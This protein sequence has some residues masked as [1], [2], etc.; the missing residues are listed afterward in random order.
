M[1]KAFATIPGLVIANRGYVL[2]PGSTTVL[3][4]AGN[5]F[6]MLM[7]GGVLANLIHNQAQSFVDFCQGF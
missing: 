4:L 1:G 5:S 7:W 6:W 3:V 2:E